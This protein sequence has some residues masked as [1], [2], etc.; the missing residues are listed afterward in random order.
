MASIF[1]VLSIH[2]EQGQRELRDWGLIPG[3]SAEILAPAESARAQGERRLLVAILN[4][5][6]QTYRKYAFSGTRRG[7]RLFGEVDAWFLGTDDTVSISFAE[8]CDL[9]DLDA[10]YIRGALTSWRATHAVAPRGG[11][12][13]P[14]VLVDSAQS[15][16]PGV[17]PSRDVA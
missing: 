8:L 3:A 15:S 6:I 2:T 17:L 12:V 1:E 11:T 14:I 7:R 5:A 10:E 9:L 4:D 16:P 13:S